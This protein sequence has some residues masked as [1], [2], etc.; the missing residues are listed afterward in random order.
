MELRFRDASALQPLG[1]LAEAG[2]A[3]VALLDDDAS[4]EFQF[5]SINL[6]MNGYLARQNLALL[7]KAIDR[8]RGVYRARAPAFVL[9]AREFDRAPAPLSESGSL[10][11]CTRP[12]L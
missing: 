2:D 5:L 3:Y 8:R 7:L 6:G 1:R 12:P 4:G 9:A 11:L 10:R